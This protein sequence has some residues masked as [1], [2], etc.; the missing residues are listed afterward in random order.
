[1]LFN[2]LVFFAF[3]PIFMV[4]Y[5]N[6]KGMARLWVCLIG[7]YF[8]YGWFDWRFMGLVAL[9]TTMDYLIGI[10]ILRYPSEQFQRR[11]IVF[12]VLINLTFLGFFKYFNF[13]IHSVN[14]GLTA[15]G[16]NPNLEVLNIILPV[17][18][19]FYTFQSM[20]Y[21]IDIYRKE[22]QPERNFI[23]FAAFVAFWPQ[24]LAGPIVRAKDFM[25]QFLEDKDW[26]WDRFWSGLGRIIW[27]FFKKMVVADSL[28][29]FA[30]Q[31][32]NNPETFSPI[33]LTLGVIFYA[34]QIYCDFSGYT[35][36][37][38]GFA[39]I[40]GFTFLEN[41]RMPYFSKGF[42]EFWTRWHISLSSWLRDYLYISMGGNRGGK[43]KMYRNLMLTMLIGG[44]W[45]GANWAFVFWG[46]LHGAYQVIQR[47]I[48]K[49]FGNLMRFLRFPQWLMDGVNMFI[50]FFLTCFAW[51]YF[52]AGSLG[53]RSFA[54]ANQII[55]TI[56]T[57][58]DWSAGSIQNKFVAAKGILVI[59]MLL[60]VEATNYKF[61]YIGNS[62][63]NWKLRA[64]LYA[65]V[66]FL[67]AA[68][69][70]FSSNAFIYF[71]F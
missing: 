23:R 60:L 42:S 62:M 48:G 2:S 65:L 7:S 46:F 15:L 26:D 22:I 69:G 45:H 19:S 71:Q 50:V 52:R 8:Y 13:F 59:G 53:D 57:G 64:V 31:C 61:S 68:L 56:A 18:I 36:I 25:P 58:D 51:I 29:P 5:F 55:G 67:I 32:F 54:V 16:M 70:T 33:H 49:P 14:S 37:A 28:A 20:S 4:L 27:G 44:L 17:G 24:L 10:S 66:L 40:L 35:D 38:I 39:R 12:S 43:L 11:M 34:F 41:F 21:T 47:I 1:M 3:I 6:T 63:T 30:D 9:T